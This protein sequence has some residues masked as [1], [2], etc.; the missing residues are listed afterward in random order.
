[1]EAHSRDDGS[2]KA[3]ILGWAPVADAKDNVS[4]HDGYDCIERFIEDFKG[5]TEIAKM[6]HDNLG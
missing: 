2:H 1:M 4:I 6:D 5:M 3:Y